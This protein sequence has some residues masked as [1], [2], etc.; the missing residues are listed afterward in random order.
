M[1]VIKIAWKD[2]IWYSNS[3]KNYC[4]IVKG[5]DA[6]WMTMSSLDFPEAKP[7]F[8]GSWHFGKFGKA[9]PEVTKAS[10][11]ENYNVKFQ[12]GPVNL[13]AVVNESGT[14][15]YLIDTTNNKLVVLK[16]LKDEEFQ[17]IKNDRDPFDAPFNP[18]VIPKPGKAGK[19]LWI[20][21]KMKNI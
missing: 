21:G 4:I 7:N 15:M 13:Y 16:C 9:N 10:G 20:S 6:K 8:I 3:V 14:K 1:S 19:L 18:Y 17:C 11:K 12:M 5:N 2:G